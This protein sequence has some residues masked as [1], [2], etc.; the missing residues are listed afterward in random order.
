MFILET[1]ELFFSPLEDKFQDSLPTETGNRESSGM[2]GK[3][4]QT[5]LQSAASSV[6]EWNYK[7]QLCR[8]QGTQ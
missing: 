4:N 3:S 8:I 2:K 7:I 6:S 1:L 5:A